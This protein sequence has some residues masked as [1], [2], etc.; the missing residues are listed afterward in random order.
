M[1]VLLVLLLVASVLDLNW[2]AAALPF[3]MPT[4][5]GEWVAGP[6]P[7]ALTVALTA[8]LV[9]LS[10]L[11]SFA[12]SL[13]TARVLH[14]HPERRARAARVYA[15]WRQVAFYLNLGITAAAIFAFGWGHWVHT[16]F[17]DLPSAA[18]VAAVMAGD[19][20]PTT[21]APHTHRLLPF[22]ELLVPAPYLLT[23]ML[24]W[25]GYWPAERALFRAAHP[26]RS[27]W[28]P[29]GFWLNNA[30]QFLVTAFLPVLLCVTHQTVTRLFPETTHHWWYQIGISFSALGLASLL[31]LVIRPLLGLKRLP[32]GPVRD[33]LEATARRLGVRF[34]DLL[35]WPTR[36]S[37]ANAMVIGVIPWARYVIFTDSLLDGLEPDELDAVFGHEAGHARYGHL[38]YYFLFLTL[39][40]GAVSGLVLLIGAVLTL[41]GVNVE[42][43][44]DSV[45]SFIPLPMLAIMGIYLFVVF[46]WLSRVCE[47]QADIFGSRTGSC[48]NPACTGHDADTPLAARGRG[49]CPTGVRSMVRALDRVMVLNGWD[50]VQGRGNLFQ[51]VMSWVRSWQHG[52]M[53]VR[54]DYLLGLIDR[55]ERADRHDRK[56]FWV[57]LV[58]VLVLLHMAAAGAVVG[59]SELLKLMM[60]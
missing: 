6:L 31:P 29:F 3:W 59:G 56:A 33:R 36:G 45:A 2:P 4:E 46:G 27:F 26:D 38:P 23:M 20:D 34:T 39:S 10:V 58:L 57:R 15:R 30:R 16:T 22:A 54:V 50:G 40:G 48:G 35:L 42:R 28:S 32:P 11:T 47:R 19:A 52:P 51:R 8:S 53:A 13:R 25:F 1:P 14:H 55:P 7:P 9:G 49:L 17:L 37:M 21:A 18:E 12:V 24:N 41:F 43:I 44:P 5:S 60:M